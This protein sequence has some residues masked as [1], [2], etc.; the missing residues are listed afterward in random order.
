[1][2]LYLLAREGHAHDLKVVVTGEGADELFWGYDLFKEVVLRELNGRDP[3][4]AAALV[5]ELY[6]YLGDGA[7]RRGPMWR[8]FLLETGAADELLGSH[9]TLS[10]IHI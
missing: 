4:R 6:G 5:D 2:P 8:Q 3:E 1:M 9:Q 7:A 10:L